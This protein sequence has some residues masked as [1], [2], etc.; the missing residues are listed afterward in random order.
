MLSGIF[1]ATLAMLNILGIAKFWPIASAG[2]YTFAVAIGVLP[3]PVTFLCTDLIG[4]FYGR[5]RANQV[6]LVGLLVSLWVGAVMWFAGVVPGFGGPEEEAFMTIRRL[7]FGALAASMIAYFVAQ[8]VDVQ[9][10]HLLRRLTDR[11]ALWLRN[12]V[13][14]LLSQYV[15]TFA[16]ITITHFYAA[17]LPIDAG[18]A[19]WPQL[20]VFILTGY[21][22]KVVVALLDTPIIYAAAW[23]MR[24]FLF[25]PHPTTSPG[26]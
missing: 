9:V 10:F 23:G 13:S 3:Y 18:R 26:Q 24:R 11:R 12:N 20:W 22:F 14:T 25:E 16:V 5:R 8:A 21:A 17:A 19:V 4:E 2:D 6:V 15:D 7:A 1:L